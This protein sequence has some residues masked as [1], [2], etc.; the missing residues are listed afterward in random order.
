[1]MPAPARPPAQVLRETFGPDL[2]PEVAARYLQEQSNG[3][4]RFRAQYARCGTGRARCEAVV[5]LRPGRPGRRGLSAARHIINAQ[6][7][8]HPTPPCSEKALSK[9]PAH[10]CLAEPGPTSEAREAAA[11]GVRRGLL[12]LRRNV[13]LLRDPENPNAFYPVGGRPVVRGHV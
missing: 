12:A 3:R 13:V 6:P 11:E 9:V 8:P 4:Y 5:R 1:M 2:A 10:R 7:C